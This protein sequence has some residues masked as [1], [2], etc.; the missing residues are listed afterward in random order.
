MILDLFQNLIQF[1]SS[2]IFFD[3]YENFGCVNIFYW[4]IEHKIS[5]QQI[6]LEICEVIL[7]EISAIVHG[8]L[9]F[10]PPEISVRFIHTSQERQGISLE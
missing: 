3:M 7:L 5:L 1:K 4:P 10:I 6:S 9:H 2:H 8:P